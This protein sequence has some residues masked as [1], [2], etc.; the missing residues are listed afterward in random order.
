[1]VVDLEIAV[2]LVV[3]TGFICGC[4]K[5]I[6]INPL[7]RAIEALGKAVSCLNNNLEKLRE[8]QHELAKQIV[9]VEQSVKSAHHRIDNVEEMV[10]K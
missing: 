4:F 6:V 8:E 3:I 2:Q 9:A 10:R 1:M 7:S 5:W